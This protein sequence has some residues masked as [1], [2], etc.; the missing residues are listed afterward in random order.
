MTTKIET[1]YHHKSFDHA[2][3]KQAVD[4]VAAF[5]QQFPPE[6]GIAMTGLS[7][8]LVGAIVAHETGRPFV[9]IR[10]QGE[11][12]HGKEVEGYV[13]KEYVIVDDF[14]DTGSS[15]ERIMNALSDR[16]C[17]A[18]FVYDGWYSKTINGVKS[19]N[20]ETMKYEPEKAN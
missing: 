2:S 18:I 6:V 9:V 11:Q 19:Y 13:F 15:M 12:S 7:G 20:H 5:M 8:I 4:Q 17:L 16:K 10:K 14:I 1:S 3:R